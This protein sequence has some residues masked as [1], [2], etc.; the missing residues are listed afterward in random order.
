MSLLRRV[1]RLEHFTVK[2]FSNDEKWFVYML[3]CEIVAHNKTFNVI[4]LLNLLLSST[5]SARLGG[6]CY[7]LCLGDNQLRHQW[8]LCHTN[9]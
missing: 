9:V 2:V 1:L 8:S 3:H 5:G 4:T 7:R 6:V